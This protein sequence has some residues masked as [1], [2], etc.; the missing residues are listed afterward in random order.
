[1]MNLVRSMFASEFTNGERVKWFWWYPPG[2][3][4]KTKRFLFKV[5]AAVVTYG[6]MSYWVKYL[7]QVNINNAFVS[8]MKEDLG[9]FGNELTWAITMFTIGTSI[10]ML[11]SNYILTLIRPSYLLPGC[12][13]LWGILTL[14]MYKANSAKMIY[15]LR[16]VIGF[17]EG[18]AFVG[19]IYCFGSWYTK[20]EL[21]RRLAIFACC[22][23]LGSMFSGYMT[24][25]IMATLDGAHGLA[26]WRWLFII[27]AIITFVVA[28]GG[29]LTFPDTPSATRSWFLNAEE[30]AFAVERLIPEGRGVEH[31]AG[32]LDVFKRLFTKQFALLVFC[33]IGWSNTLGKYLGTVFSLY[34]KND[35][36]RWSIYQVK[37]L[38]QPDAAHAH[39]SF[40]VQINN[41]P[42]SSGGF[43]IAA[44]LI[45]GWVIDMTGRRYMLIVG[46][47]LTQ[48]LGTVLYLSYDIGVGGQIAAL[49]LG[50][51]D[52]PTSPIIMTWANLLLG[53]DAQRRALTIACMNA[54]GSAVST[55]VN[56]YGYKALDAPKM[57]KGICISLAFVCFELVCVSV[58]R[59]I[60][61][62]T[63]KDRQSDES[64]DQA[65]GG[66]NGSGS[67]DLATEEKKDVVAET[68]VGAI[69]PVATK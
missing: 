54:F 33:W 10:A 39:K 15:G 58:L 38:P 19:M 14:V 50:A 35:P 16:F 30:R 8:G 52:G 20:R 56:T 45:S 48:I 6:C 60:E 17:L 57:R 27:D 66:A 2:T 62:T 67:M 29:F 44:M 4:A 24:S 41:I 42:T 13:F 46:F 26:G 23:Y 9:L 51:L 31:N 12:E 7:D 1:M 22:A 37:L 25:S 69:V 47:L 11:P 5:D 55:I 64:V 36:S 21:G 59:Y 53:G 49:L 34:L 43:N 18:S 65:E 61:L 68:P 63:S 28:I 40:R 3:D 32:G